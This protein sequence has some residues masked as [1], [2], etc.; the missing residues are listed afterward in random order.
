[1]ARVDPSVLLVVSDAVRGLRE[2]G[3]DFCVVEALVPE[4]LLEARP[5][6]MTNDAD[7]TVVVQSLD[8]FDRLKTRLNEF[9]F[10]NTRLPHRMKHQSGG[11]LDLLPFSD[12]IAPG[13]RLELSE[14][15]VLNMVGFG[16]VVPNSVAAQIDDGP[17][18]PLAPLPLYVLLKLVAFSD[19]RA[20]KDLGGVLHCLENYQADDDR[21]YGLDHEEEP[22]PFEYTCAYLIGL[23]GQAFHDEPLTLAVASVLDQFDDP[24]AGV[25]DIVAREKGRMFADDRDRLEIFEMFRWFRL[26][27]H[28]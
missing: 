26:G 3:V 23:D 16:Q 28:L 27:S 15:I 18:V 17:S 2:I 1:M 13:G 21:R 7:I 4:L 12:A 11:L 6:K 19:R 8:E 10:V 22:V 24:D 5:R 9:G 14:D 20:P 25:V